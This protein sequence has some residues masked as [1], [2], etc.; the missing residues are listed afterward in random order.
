LHGVDALPCEV[1]VD[2]DPDDE[3]KRELVVGLPDAAVRE[4]IERVRSALA[5]CGYMGI[6]GRLLVNLA[7]A[8]VRKEGPLY[9]LPIAVGLLMSQGVIPP[10]PTEG[11]PDLRRIVI[12]GELAL[13]GRVRPIRGAIAMAAMAA[14]RGC[15]AVIV[16]ADNASEAAVV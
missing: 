2:L 6:R 14:E 12:A 8:D 7:P 9:D 1:E 4:S 16:P 15:T 10:Q 11:A 13:D 5:N 3:Q